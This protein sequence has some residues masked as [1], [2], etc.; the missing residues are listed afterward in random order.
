M[1]KKLLASLLTVLMLMNL[2]PVLALAVEASDIPYLDCEE[3]D[4]TGGPNPVSKP[5]K[6]KVTPLLG[7]TAGML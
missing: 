2:F 6:W 7:R 5:Q 3:T 1:K 4:R